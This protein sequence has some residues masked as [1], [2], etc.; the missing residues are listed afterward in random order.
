L[1]AGD[2]FVMDLG[3]LAFHKSYDRT[4]RHLRSK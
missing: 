1:K 3:K 2:R 4:G